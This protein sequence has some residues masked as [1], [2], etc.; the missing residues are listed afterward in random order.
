MPENAT[1]APPA[2][3]SDAA[4]ESDRLVLIF[5][6]EQSQ[7]TDLNEFTF[8]TQSARLRDRY[9]PDGTP[10]TYDGTIQGDGQSFPI[11]FRV[12]SQDGDSLRCGFFDLPIKQRESILAL[13]DRI[14]SEGS[15]E[16]HSLSYDELAGGNTT[17]ATKAQK[18]KTAD[19]SK[20]ASTLKKAIAMSLM[21]LA[22]AAIVGWIFIVVQTRSTVSV[23]NSVLVGNYQPVN[24]PFQGKLLDV[25]VSVGDRVTEG[26]VVALVG[27]ED[28]EHELHMLDAQLVRTRSE[29]SAYQQQADRIAGLMKFAMEKADRD[30]TVAKAELTGGQAEYDAAKAQVDRLAPLVARGNIGVFEVE[31]AKALAARAKAAIARQNALIETFQL[32]KSAAQKSVLVGVNGVSDPLSEVLT[33]IE[34]AK[35]AINE[36]SSIRNSLAVKNKPIELFAP[37][38]GTVY[39]IYRRKG[40][41]LKI[42][43]EAIAVSLDQTGWATGHVSPGL[44]AQVRPGQPV[45]I[46]IPSMGITTNGKV[47]GIGHRSVY[48]RGGYNAEFRGGPLEVPIRVELDPSNEKIPSGLRLN[49][50]V[51]VH[52]HLATMKK[53]IGSFRSGDSATT[54][55]TAAPANAM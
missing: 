4:A 11:Q 9:Q 13:R 30:L 5:D 50:T 39:A 33:K 44:A 54:A 15:D 3:N 12:R 1:L 42:A 24:T 8:V 10:E 48:G 2:A 23:S 55:V 6:S 47:A 53:W 31:E 41:Y 27:K 14:Q 34:L 20:S 35:A 51:R 18:T 19:G 38:D 49:M 40:E 26:Q 46:D 32:S 16:L 7:V 28:L 52:D 36:A 29:L 25:L 22:M 17:K 43:D 21:V 45:E 37:Q